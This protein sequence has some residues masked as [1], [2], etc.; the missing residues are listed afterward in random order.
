M[1]L[2]FLIAHPPRGPAG[3]V[4][5]EHA[6]ANANRRPSMRIG[7]GFLLAFGIGAACRIAGFMA[8]DMLIAA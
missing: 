7:L 5:A 8:A 1:T 3:R 2:A 4:L 6:S